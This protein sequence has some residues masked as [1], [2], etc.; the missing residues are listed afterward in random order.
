[1]VQLADQVSLMREQIFHFMGSDEVPSPPHRL[2][3][4]PLIGKIIRRILINME[5]ERPILAESYGK[6]IH[7]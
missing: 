5:V 1:M 6:W 7:V 3:Q 4:S 2:P